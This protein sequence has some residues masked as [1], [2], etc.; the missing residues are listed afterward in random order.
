MPVAQPESDSL[1]IAMRSGDVDG[2]RLALKAAEGGA[3]DGVDE[4]EG[5]A[6]AIAAA[7]AELARLEGVVRRFGVPGMGCAEAHAERLGEER[8]EGADEGAE[9]LG[10]WVAHSLRVDYSDRL[11]VK[12]KVAPLTEVHM[13]PLPV[14]RL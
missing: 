2:L 9:G 10:A 14:A 5:G 7:A 1:A 8:A 3:K 12:T 6:E 13:R 4:V 11:F